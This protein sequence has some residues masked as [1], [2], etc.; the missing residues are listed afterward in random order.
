[1]EFVNLSVHDRKGAGKGVARKLRHEGQVPAV[2]YGAGVEPRPL[3][4]D[5]GVLVEILRAEGG[6]HQLLNLEVEGDDK[7][8]PAVIKDFQLDPVTDRV[9][10]VDFLAVRE[11]RVIVVDVPLTLVGEPEG[12]VEGGMVEQRVMTLRV[13]CLPKHL[14]STVEVGVS[15]LTL[16]DSVTLGEVVRPEGVTIEGDDSLPLAAVVITRA[17][18][19][20]ELEVELEAIAEGEE[21]EVTETEEKK[22]PDKEF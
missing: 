5:K 17:A 4:V 14:P 13:S 7:V 15:H 18:M 6:E 1:M 2:Y 12:L 9:L 20:E 16:G 19:A 8:L 3:S 22:E 10:H 11:D 21:A